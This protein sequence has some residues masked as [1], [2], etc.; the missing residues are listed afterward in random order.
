M[1]NWKIKD[2]YG[3]RFGKLIVLEPTE[4]RMNNS[5]VWVC[6]CDCGTIIMIA[7]QNL[8]QGKGGTKSC[9]CLQKELAVQHGRE[10]GGYNALDL[11]GNR[12]DR[13][14]VIKKLLKKEKD[15]C[16]WWVC[17]CDC[18]ETTSVRGFC[19]KGGITKSCGCLRDATRFSQHTNIN[20]MDVPFEITDIIKTRRGIKR[21]I[22][23]AS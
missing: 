12:F 19:L 10:L 9:G 21:F 15:G 20:P 14:K 22:K 17:K 16:T 18:G 8:R 7:N 1:P 23:Q 6:K 11:N 4:L 5:V 13:L 3:K 2:I